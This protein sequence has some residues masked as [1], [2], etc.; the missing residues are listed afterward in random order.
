MSFLCSSDTYDSDVYNPEAPSIT[1]TSRPVYR[2]RVN[3]QRPNLIG[4]TMGG[5]DQPPRGI[6][7]WKPP[8]HCWSCLS[9]DI[10]FQWKLMTGGKRRII[11]AS[12]PNIIMLGTFVRVRACCCF[13]NKNNASIHYMPRICVSCCC[14]SDVTWVV[15]SIPAVCCSLTADLLLF[16][17]FPDKIPNNSMRIVMESDSRKRSAVSHDGGIPIKKPWFDK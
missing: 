17:S 14:N 2:H 6:F 11:L 8:Q 13:T 12:S 15:I 1:N 4:L 3:A 16:V 5:V 10:D 9:C 7:I